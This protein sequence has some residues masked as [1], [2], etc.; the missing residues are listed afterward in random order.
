MIERWSAA[1]R[2]IRPRHGALELGSEP[3]EIHHRGEPFEI[4]H[5][6]R[7]EGVEPG[8]CVSTEG[9]PGFKVVVTRHFYQ[10]GEQVRT[11]D[12]RTKY[13]PENLFRMNN[14]IKPM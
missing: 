5:D 13:D 14:N 3:L 12:F 1:L 11:E 10:G 8:D 4:E 2:S 9:V 6:P 7:P